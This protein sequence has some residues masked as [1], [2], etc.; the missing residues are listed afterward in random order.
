[1]QYDRIG[2][3]EVSSFL[4]IIKC[5]AKYCGHVPQWFTSHFTDYADYHFMSRGK[6]F[7]CPQFFFQN[8]SASHS[9]TQLRSQLLLRITASFNNSILFNFAGIETAGLSRDCYFSQGKIKN[10]PA[11][12]EMTN[13]PRNPGWKFVPSCVTAKYQV[14]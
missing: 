4:Q 12:G 10:I 7:A 8:N 9:K 1:M 2:D 3:K 14:K 11:L 5:K 6:S 13:F